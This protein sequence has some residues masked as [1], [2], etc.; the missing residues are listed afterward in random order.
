MGVVET[1]AALG[2][3]I[4]AADGDD[5]VADGAIKGALVGLALKV[6]TP[7]VIV[8]GVGFLAWRGIGQ[9]RERFGKSEPA[10]A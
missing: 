5:G 8:A 4:D 9:L 3:I 10:T 7:I 1:G 2:A 6:V